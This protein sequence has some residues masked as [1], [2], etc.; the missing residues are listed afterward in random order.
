MCV[1]AHPKG[2]QYQLLIKSGHMNYADK[3]KEALAKK[4]MPHQADGAVLTKTQQKAAKRS[5]PPVA[6]GKPVRKAAGR[7]G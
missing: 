3:L 4:Q 1:M 2:R 6:A 5:A 7:G